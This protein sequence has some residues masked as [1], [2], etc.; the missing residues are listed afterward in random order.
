MRW[1]RRLIVLF[2]VGLL[3]LYPLLAPPPHRI[4]KAHCDLIKKGMTKDEVESIFGAP[5]GEYDFTEQ[6]S[7]G[8][9][10][11]VRAVKFARVKATIVEDLSRADLSGLAV[12]PLS[13]K[14]LSTH[15]RL[16]PTDWKTWTGR[17]GA[18]T[19]L[20]DEQGQVV[21]TSGP[22]EV[23]IVPPWQRWWKKLTE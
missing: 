16:W 22:H 15:V 7:F 6:K 2:L 12:Q 1:P 11:V 21:S 19:V 8:Y 18:F 4:D 3:G 5:P 10:T 13:V 20:F 14:R 23:T 17:H 9:L